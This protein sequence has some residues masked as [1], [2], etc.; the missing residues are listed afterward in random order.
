MRQAHRPTGVAGPRMR[1][2]VRP[3]PLRALAA[4]GLLAS[5]A[6]LGTVAGSTA[7]TAPRPGTHPDFA[8]VAFASATTGWVAGPW[9]A[10]QARQSQGF[11]WYTA[12]G[13]RTWTSQYRGPVAVEGLTAASATTAYAWGGKTV[14]ATAD[15]GIRWS[16]AATLPQDVTSVAV[17]PAGTA[18]AVAGGRLYEGTA[19]SAVWAR[20]GAAADLEKVAFP[21]ANVGWALAAGDRVYRT[22]DGGRTWSLSFAL[23]GSRAG[24]PAGIGNGGSLVVAGDA[25]VWV[26]FIGGS[27]MS[28]TSYSVY[29]TAGGT[30]HAVVAVSTAGAGPAPG[31]AMGTSAGPEVPGGPGSSP[32]PMAAL[33]PAG[34]Y[35]VGECQ[36]C[37]Q[38]RMM[39]SVKT[40]D[41]GRTWTSPRSI[42]LADG[43]SSLADLSFPTPQ[44]G[45]LAVP[46][47]FSGHGQIL[48]ST[49]GGR[50]WRVV[51]ER[52][53]VP[54]VA[55]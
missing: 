9:L 34:L 7:A 13:G 1:G 30:W 19:R 8:A 48:R 14:L 5:C 33:G 4:A 23:P 43:L 11:I 22:S 45:Y 29:H 28:Q 6:L 25:S 12:D 53:A 36:A 2:R 47:F 41:N 51:W 46:A 55:H 32:G 16:V 15:S 18:Y 24:V 39:D 50:L 3:R 17:T 37:S 42:A 20:V 31:A 54:P 10:P 21:S 52:S 44:V 38:P 27:G 49:D 35:L 26:L 40:R